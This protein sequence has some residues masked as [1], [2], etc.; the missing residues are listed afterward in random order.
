MFADFCRGRTSPAQLVR[1]PVARALLRMLPK[2]AA[3]KVFS[4]E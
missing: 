2:Q 3:A 1:N 4:G